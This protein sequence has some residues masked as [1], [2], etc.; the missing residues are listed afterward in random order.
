MKWYDAAELAYHNGYEA[1]FNDGKKAQ[2]E[3]NV[4]DD[5]VCL[6]VCGIYNATGGIGQCKHR[7]VREKVE[8][9]TKIRASEPN[10]V[11]L[12]MKCSRCGA[13]MLEQDHVCPACGAIMRGEQA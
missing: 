12:T 13:Y 3:Q 2:N 8:Y 10:H 1:G 4:C 7:T 5:C 9:A 11:I 6:P